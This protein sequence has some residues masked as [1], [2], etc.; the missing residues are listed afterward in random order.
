MR[1]SYAIAAAII[2]VAGVAASAVL[3]IQ[4]GFAYLGIT[5]NEGSMGGELYV[6]AVETTGELISIPSVTYIW[7]EEEEVYQLT[8]ADRSVGGTL[9][10][11]TPGDANKAL[12]FIVSFQ[13]PGSW[14]F[15]DSIKVNVSNGCPQGGYV[16]YGY[17]E[18]THAYETA[19]NKVSLGTASTGTYTFEINVIYKSTVS[20]DPAPYQGEN[21][22]STVVFLIE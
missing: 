16:V 3:V 6:K 1:K 15:I 8:D 12:N 9:T 18:S 21:M 13:D 2:A 17:N 19:G 5:D 20:I 22:K 14:M 7:Y 10:V 4:Y 11:H